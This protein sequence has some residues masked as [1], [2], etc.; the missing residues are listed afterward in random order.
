[1]NRF[2]RIHRRVSYGLVS[3]GL[4]LLFFSGELSLPVWGGALVAMAAAWHR[5]EKPVSGRYATA[6]WNGAL[7]VIFFALSSLSVTTGNW[8]LYMTQ[9]A[10]VMTVSKF[11]WV[12]ASR[13]ILQLYVLSFLLVLGGAVM[14]PGISFGLVLL[15]YVVLLTWGL[16]LL[17]FRREMEARAAATAT[18]ERRESERFWETRRLVTGSFLAGTSLLAL[19]IF[20]FSLVIFFFFPRLGL[21]FFSANTRR[22]QAVSGFGNDLRLGHFGT[23]RDD[24]AVVLRIELPDEPAQPGRRLRVRGISFDTYDGRGWTKKDRHGRVMRMGPEGTYDVVQRARIP[25]PDPRALLRQEIYLEPIETGRRVL[26]GLPRIRYVRRPGAKLKDLQ[27]GGVTGSQRFRLRFVIDEAG[28][29]S[30]T[31]GSDAAAFRYTVFSDIRPYGGQ[32]PDPGGRVPDTLASRYTQLPEG[33][34]ARVRALAEELSKDAETPLD[35]ARALE[36]GLQ[37][38]W[39][40]SLEG[41]HDPDDPLADFLFS[42]KEGHCEYFATSMAVL[43]RSIGLP[44]RPVNG[45]YGG[46]WNHFGSYY[47]IRQADAHSWVEVYLAGA[48]WVTFDPTPAAERYVRGSSGLWAE[49]DAWMDSVRLRWYKWVIEYDL[50]KQ[51]GVVSGLFQFLAPGGSHN[52]A[53]MGDRRLATLKRAVKQLFSWQNLLV[54]GALIA[55]I[56]LYRAFRRRQRKRPREKRDR[57]ARR[58]LSGALR[59]FARL[60]RQMARHGYPRAVS[61][62]PREWAREIHDDEYPGGPALLDAT[63]ALEEI[64][65]GGRPFDETRR[66]RFEAAIVAC[67]V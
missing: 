61:R 67:Q 31:G 55:A 48:G 9:Y 17:H 54:L 46:V 33:L 7:I 58:D 12:R 39:R 66:L 64:V 5:W 43:A 40:Y 2:S 34:S 65:W 24:E 21:G 53:S 18:G 41:G 29:V 4:L 16:V 42:R 63:T 10:I 36:R 62:S 27:E 11:F 56:A 47:A 23:I 35:K 37:S 38:G 30:R 1:M 3:T 22:S 57:R 49:I 6:L 45:F 51:L 19:G 13:D 8:L 25:Q 44:A 52:D 15:L 59:L 26:F 50:D 60:E 32:I 28:D 14:N 20:L